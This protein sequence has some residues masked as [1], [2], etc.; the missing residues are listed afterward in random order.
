MKWKPEDFNAAMRG[1]FS[2]VRGILFYGPDR[3]QTLENMEAAA[4][5]I[6]PVDDGFSIFEFDCDAMKKDFSEAASR[7]ADEAASASFTGSR[8]VVKIKNAPG[9]LDIS[10]MLSADAD[11]AMILVAS[12][13]L[14]PSSALRAAAE[15]SPGW[16]ALP[17][18]NDDAEDVERMARKIL[19]EA[20]IARVPA[21][22]MD[23]IK[24]SLGE[25]RAT[26]RSELSK[27]ALYLHGR[28]QITAGDVAACIMDS[29]L[30]AA[31]DIAMATA[32][33]EPMRLSRVLSRALAEGTSAVQILNRVSRH[34][35]RLLQMAGE[36]EGGAAAREVVAR[37]RPMIFFKLRPE[38][39]R[40]LSLWPCVSIMRAIARLADCDTMCKAQGRPA[41]VLVSQALL[42][43]A[44]MRSRR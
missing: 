28:G 6:C 33:R 1:S 8:K 13:E 7:A 21:A 2:G 25:N 5:R 12:G 29:S 3:G 31:E 20:G 40:Q 22:A 16:A 35:M 39:E 32:S 19:A 15:N 23:S 17:S 41:E 9:E 4:A 37:A 42:S 43:L 14:S 11:A 30:M 34:F 36:V 24:T 26:T 38:F 10:H 27:L 18:Y 44:A